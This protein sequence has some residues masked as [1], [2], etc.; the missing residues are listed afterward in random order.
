MKDTIVAT[1]EKVSVQTVSRVKKDFLNA[2][3]SESAI[4]RKNR[5]NPPV[6][7]RITSEIESHIISICVEAPPAG[8][9][10]WTLRLIAKEAVELGYIDAISHTTVGKILKK[11]KLDLV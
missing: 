4:R 5:K 10:R 6:P 9:R 7:V 8:C 11:N 1:R 2:P 3:E